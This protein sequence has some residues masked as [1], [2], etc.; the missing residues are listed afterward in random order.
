MFVTWL[1]GEG[2]CRE[3]FSRFTTPLSVYTQRPYQTPL[4]TSVPRGGSPGKGRRINKR[5]RGDQLSCC[6]LSETLLIIM[7]LN[8]QEDLKSQNH[9]LDTFMHS[10]KKVMTYFNVLAEA[11]IKSQKIKSCDRS[12][13][14]CTCS[15]II[16]T[17]INNCKSGILIQ[18]YFILYSHSSR[19]YL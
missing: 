9:I 3:S 15:Y 16:S 12:E 6:L 5:A 2:D 1:F 4:I 19:F 18:I 13:Y 10:I 14:T 17:E 7:G 11:K 8:F